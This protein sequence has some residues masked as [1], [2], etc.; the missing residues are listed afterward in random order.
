MWD[1]PSDHGWRALARRVGRLLHSWWQ[2]D[3]IR[4][5]PAEGRS[6]TLR[7]PCWLLVNGHS[8]EI[9]DWE[10]W[11]RAGRPLVVYTCRTRTGLGTLSVAPCSAG[12]EMVIEWH[13]GPTVLRLLETDVEVYSPNE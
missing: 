13:D 9:L 2:G 7:P 11:H 12:Q 8:L 10:V 6:L 5:A 4:I 3:R 1:R